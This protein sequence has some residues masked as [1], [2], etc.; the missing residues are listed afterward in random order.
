[1]ARRLRGRPA[2]AGLGLIAGGSMSNLADRLVGGHVIDFLYVGIGPLHTG[3]FNVADA[4]ILAGGI[5]VV[6][7][8]R[9]ADRAASLPRP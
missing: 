6:A 8:G 7:F 2:L 9:Q 4:A 5:L 3:I 1:L